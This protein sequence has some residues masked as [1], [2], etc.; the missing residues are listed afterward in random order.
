MAQQQQENISELP[1][2]LDAMAEEPSNPGGAG[3]EVHLQRDDKDDEV[4]SVGSG[5]DEKADERENPEPAAVVKAEPSEENAPQPR[6]DAQEAKDDVQAPAPSV[7]ALET[8]E[9]AQMQD[10]ADLVSRT[11]PGV[12]IKVVGNAVARAPSRR[13]SVLRR[14]AM[15]TYDEGQEATTSMGFILSA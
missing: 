4:I 8:Q 14:D 6:V 13:P 3:V 15:P 1:A 2:S 11:V 5:F 9:D 10:A 7:H 12:E